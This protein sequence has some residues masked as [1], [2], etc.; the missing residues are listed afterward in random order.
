MELALIL[1]TLAL[2][3][4]HYITLYTMEK[5]NKHNTHIIEYRGTRKLNDNKDLK[6]K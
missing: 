5:D 3:A 4:V 6:D 2:V 1:S